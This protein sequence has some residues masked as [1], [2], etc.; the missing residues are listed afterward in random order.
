MTVMNPGESLNVRDLTMQINALPG[1]FY[2]K[3][4]QGNYLTYNA[5][6]LALLASQPNDKE[7]LLQFDKKHPC[8]EFTLLFKADEQKV[9]AFKK[10]HTALYEL[11]VGHQKK[12]IWLQF[13]RSPLYQD[14]TLIGI[15]AIGLDVSHL[16]CQDLNIVEEALLYNLEYVVDH[17]PG[18]IYWKDRESHYIGCNDNLVRASGLSHRSELLGKTDYDFS[19]GKKNAR[20]FIDDDQK[21]MRDR[22]IHTTEYELPIMRDDGRKL[23]VRTDKMPLINKNNEVIGVLAIAIDITDQ[24]MLEEKLI[25]EKAHV[26]L[27][28]QAKTEFMRNM[29]HDIRT[30]FSGICTLANGLYEQEQDPEKKDYLFMVAQSANELLEYCNNI[31]DFSRLESGVLPAIHKKFA[32]HALLESI[33]KM[34]LPAAQAKGLALTLVSDP[35]IP[36]I[37]LGDPYRLQRI[38]INLMGNAIKFTAK[39]FIK[40]TSQLICHEAKDVIIRISVADTGMGIPADKID[41]VYERFLRL[42]P[43]NQGRYKGS[44]LGLAIVK[45]LIEEMD[46]EIDIKSHEQ[47]GTTFI[48]TLVFKQPL[49]DEVLS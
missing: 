30:P 37:L 35:A 25:Q 47:Q 2:T 8:D 23:M 3:D 32:I 22:A 7:H 42:N 5:N 45:Q 11:S 33:V 13:E 48:C 49:V 10:N 15:Q 34:E 24:K 28:S 31:V 27:L 12:S 41:S 14:N 36:A 9:I 21:V 39:G 17:M 43:S 29:E 40:I 18:Y 26:E 20:Q 46:G 44:G 4:L 6:F 38:L 1:Y 16:K 19:W